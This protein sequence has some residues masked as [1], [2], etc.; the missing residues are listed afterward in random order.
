ML[1][2]PALLSFC[3]TRGM[4]PAQDFAS[5]SGKKAGTMQISGTTEM[6]HAVWANTHRAVTTIP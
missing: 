5:G 3:V 4:D 6:A 2:A 1:V